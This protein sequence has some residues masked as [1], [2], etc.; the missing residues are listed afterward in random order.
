MERTGYESEVM[1]TSI[2][3]GSL[4]R[5]FWISIRD[6]SIPWLISF[7]SSLFYIM[8]ND[9][10]SKLFWIVESSESLRDS[11]TDDVYFMTFWT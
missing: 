5:K 10:Y 2:W 9:D 3:S 11:K 7:C 4:Q 8:R 6:I 1:S